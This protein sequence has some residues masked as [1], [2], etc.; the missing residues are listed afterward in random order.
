[1]TESMQ[2]ALVNAKCMELFGKKPSEMNKEELLEA[3]SF[4]A[5]KLGYSS[6]EEA[7][8]LMLSAELEK[9]KTNDIHQQ[10]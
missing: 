7:A 10:I 3:I 1:M 5:N 2:N 4:I 6:L 8:N 9:E